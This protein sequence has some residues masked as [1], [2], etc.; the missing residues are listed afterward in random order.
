MINHSPRFRRWVNR[1][2]I[3]SLSIGLTTMILIF[4]STYQRQKYNQTSCEEWIRR[5]IQPL[6]FE[7]IIQEK[8]ISSDEECREKW[9]LNIEEPDFLEI[10]QCPENENLAIW[11]EKGDSIFKKSGKR[12]LYV[13]KNGQEGRSFA[14]PCCE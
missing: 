12:T 5:T 3:I 1:L 4:L 6:S 9:V 2:A 7:A 14:Y 10:C 8:K 13:K 11:A